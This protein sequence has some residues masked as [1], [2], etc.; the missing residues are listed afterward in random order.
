MYFSCERDRDH[1][2][3]EGRLW[4]TAFGVALT[5]HTS[6]F[7]PLCDLLLCMNE[8]CDVLL[9]SRI[10]QRQWYIY[11]YGYMFMITLH[12]AAIHLVRRPSLP[13]W[14]WRSKL[15]YGKDHAARS[16][17]QPPPN[18][19][20]ENEVLSL[21][22]CKKLNALHELGSKSD[23]RQTFEVHRQVGRKE[24]SQQASIPWTGARTPQG[25]IGTCVSS[26]CF[27]PCWQGCLQKLRF[28][29]MEQS[30]CTWPRSQKN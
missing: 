30:T 1:W 25:Q 3:Q 2:G 4:W 8:T 5:F 16:W 28:F 13:C 7:Q 23:P 10:W 12:K 9:T 18:S 15:P 11:I 17:K 27:W 24:G 21:T 26:C 29:I 22:T 6:W 19:Q 20:Q 14:L